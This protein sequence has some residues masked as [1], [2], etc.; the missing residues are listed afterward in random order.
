MEVAGCIVRQSTQLAKPCSNPCNTTWQ[1]AQ[2]TILGPVS[3]APLCTLHT[4]TIKCWVRHRRHNAALYRVCEDTARYSSSCNR[5][6]QAL[7]LHGVTWCDPKS[8]APQTAIKTPPSP[9]SLCHSC[10]GAWA[11]RSVASA[12]PVA[13]PAS[14]PPVLHRH[15]YRTCTPAASLP[16]FGMHGPH[17]VQ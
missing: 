11:V 15:T 16:H 7:E 13:C 1:L 14:T 3:H 5:T 17:G 9:V 6:H 10:A 4:S 8:T 12:C 2:R